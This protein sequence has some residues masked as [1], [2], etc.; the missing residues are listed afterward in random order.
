MPIP[1]ADLRKLKTAVAKASEGRP[2]LSDFLDRLRGLHPDLDAALDG[3]YTGRIGEV[4]E[5][6][7]DWGR[8]ICFNWYSNDVRKAFVEWSY[9]S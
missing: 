2:S 4:R 3:I 7:G 8:M 1:S 6:I 5:P 9:I